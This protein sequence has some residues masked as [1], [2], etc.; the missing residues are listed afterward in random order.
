M[1]VLYL[2]VAYLLY[3]AVRRFVVKSTLSHAVLFAI[4]LALTAVAFPVASALMATGRLRH[5]RQTQRDMMVARITEAGG[6]AA[7][8]TDCD[9]IVE[10]CRDST[11]YWHRGDTNALPATLASLAPKEIR[12]YSPTVLSEFKEEP[13]VAVVRI[14]VFGLHSTGGHSTPYF[15]LEVVSGAGAETYKPR[16]SRGGVSGNHYDSYR[17]VTDRIYEVY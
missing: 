13:Q 16:P 1:L 8:Q 15:G 7:L 3:L 2:I 9:E 12:Y 10:H 6:W 17:I 5:E 14:K 4:L 11:F